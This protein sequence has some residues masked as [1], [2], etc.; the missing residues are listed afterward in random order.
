MIRKINIIELAEPNADHIPRATI[1]K[2]VT[3]SS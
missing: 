3:E 2:L 1:Y